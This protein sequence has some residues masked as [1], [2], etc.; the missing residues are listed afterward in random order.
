[1]SIRKVEHLLI[2]GGLASAT[3]AQ[4]LREEG[5][6]GQIL[7]VGREPDPPYHRPPC[8][9]GYLRGAETREDT[10]VCSAR[11]YVEND[12]ELMTRTSVTALDL[13]T[14][15]AKLSNRE[16]IGFGRALI[17]TGANVRR[18]N[19]PGCELEEIHYLRALGNADAI[20]RSVA[21]AEDVVL[22]GGS[23][24]G[25]EVAASLTLMGKRCSIVMQEALTLE[26]G[27]GSRAARFF[28]DLL[29]SRGVHVYGEDE[30]ERIEGNGRVSKVLTRRGRELQAQTVVIGA[31]VIPDSTLA[32]GA[33]LA[34]SDGGG[35]RCSALL[36]SSAG[37]VFA[38]GD[39]C[40]YDSPVHHRRLR[41]EHWDA[42]LKQGRTAAL[43]M[44]GR[45][46]PHDDVPYFFSDLADWASL[47]Y[48]GAPGEHDREI[49]RG[50]FEQGDFS[51]WYLEDGRVVGALSVGRSED[52]DHARRLIC[53]DAALADAQ[54]AVL[55]DDDS[56]LHDLAV[57]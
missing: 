30:L 16:E 7:L 20:R 47:E 51:N 41:F 36:E 50:S 23:F 42:A 31:G 2:G 4:T 48:V 12:V 40:E 24:I 56:D 28:H 32:R 44:L 1:M 57:L 18:L 19:F 54:L 21:D 25:C 29:S 3:A 34:I 15:T 46:D 43:N 17:A 27:L 9:K 13:Q 10:L 53:S 5:G 6:E 11:W 22:I 8:S 33:G 52:L 35:V 45:Q 26:R 39:V 55:A 38:A 14:R 49:T 37:G